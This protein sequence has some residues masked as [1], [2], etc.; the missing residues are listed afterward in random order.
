VKLTPEERKLSAIL[1][2]ILALG[3]FAIVV[4]DWIEGKTG[5][6]GGNHGR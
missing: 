1:G 4:I 3:W 5:W 2:G 6:I